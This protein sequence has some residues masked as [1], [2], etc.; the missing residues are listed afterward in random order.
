MATTLRDLGAY[1]NVAK[2]KALDLVKV[3]LPWERRFRYHE[4]VAWWSDQT[5]VAPYRRFLQYDGVRG[6]PMTRIL[7]RRFQLLNL[8]QSVS[9]LTGCTAEC[10][11]YRGVGSGIICQALRETY[12]ADTWH[13]GF[14]SFEGLPEPDESDR[15]A[16]GR[17]HWSRVKL[18]SD[19]ATVRDLLAEFPFARV[20]KGWIPDTF[21]PA[22]ECRFRFVHI[23]V[24]LKHP[25]ADSLRFFYPRLVSGGVIVLDDHGFTDCPGARA[26]AEEFFADKP[27]KIVEVPTGQAFIYKR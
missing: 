19:F 5:W 7:D 4:R 17:H 25:T 21:G 26:A 1:A 9:H 24:D 3:A 18:A 2:Y 27:E 14:D 20:I 16:N 6:H 12:A 8:A 11:V 15:M 22:A 13:F 10:G 23:D